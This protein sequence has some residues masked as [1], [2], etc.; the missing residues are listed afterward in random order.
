MKNLNLIS[1]LTITFFTF[2]CNKIYYSGNNLE[3]G[4]TFTGSSNANLELYVDTTILLKGSS[5]TTVVLGIFKSSD[6]VYSDA[7]KGGIADFEKR[8]AMYK[9]LESTNYDLIVLPKYKIETYKGLLT[10]STTC[11]VEGYGGKYV[12]KN[13]KYISNNSTLMK[14]IQQKEEMLIDSVK[15][16]D[17]KTLNKYNNLEDVEIGDIVEYL[18]RYQQKIYGIVLEIKPNKKIRMKTYPSQGQEF[19]IEDKY[20]FFK[21]A[22]F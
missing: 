8:A 4:I 17:N 13:V 2:S 12:L 11:Y 19:I 18:D 3:P 6:N 5:T 20:T 22:I 7:Y 10:K 21:K 1:L 15:N 14:N 16:I 9:A